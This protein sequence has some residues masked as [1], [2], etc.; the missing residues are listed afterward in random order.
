VEKFRSPVD[1]FLDE[2]LKQ[3]NSYPHQ[4]VESLKNLF[5]E[6]IDLVY[7]IFG[8][9]AFLLP[10]NQTREYKSPV[11]SIYDPIMQAFSKNLVYR[12]SLLRNSTTIREKIYSIPELLYVKG[13]KN[14]NLFDGRYNNRTD[15][16][17]RIDYFNDFLQN[18]IE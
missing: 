13:D 6:T 8:D 9:S 17:S 7:Q 15:I 16:Q 12:D 14:R 5:N 2:Y 18:Y 3:A 1:R 11:K 10:S 4:T